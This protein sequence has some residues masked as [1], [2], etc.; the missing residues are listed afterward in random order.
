[1]TDVEKQICILHDVKADNYK[2]GVKLDA[3]QGGIYVVSNN[4][5]TGAKI[6]IPGEI[7]LERPPKDKL[8]AVIFKDLDTDVYARN[9]VIYTTGTASDVLLVCDDVIGLIVSNINPDTAHN[10]KIKAKE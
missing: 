4:K 1:M 5:F 3:P 9:S 6:R 2:D 8:Q 10:L 7:L